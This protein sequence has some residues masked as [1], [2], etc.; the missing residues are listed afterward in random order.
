[1]VKLSTII[2]AHTLLMNGKQ[3]DFEAAAAQLGARKNDFADWTASVSAWASAFE[4]LT[5]AQ[6]KQAALL[7]LQQQLVSG[8]LP[9][10]PAFEIWNGRRFVPTDQFVKDPG[11]DLDVTIAMMQ[12]LPATPERGQWINALAELRAARQNRAAA[13]RA[14][15]DFRAGLA[16][17]VKLLRELVLQAFSREDV[18]RALVVSGAR[19]VLTPTAG[20]GQTPSK[21]NFASVDLGA[22][23][24]FPGFDTWTL[25]Y[26]GLNVYTVPV[27]RTIPPGELT[28]TTLDQLRQRVSL[29]IGTTLTAPTSPGRTLSAPFLGRYPLLAVGVRFGEYTRAVVGSVFYDANDP[30][31][32]SADKRLH[33][34]LFFGASLD[35][36]VI[37]I[38][39]NKL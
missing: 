13:E 37:D 14:P 3:G 7:L 39:T 1:L 2:Q 28:G 33:A 12:L 16:A 31:P 15:G 21:A 34:A 29:T 20:L 38:L 35:A 18:R 4:T 26:L 24:A 8:Q 23:V 10:P 5:A 19:S 27:D 6:D 9:K 36:D 22:A 17:Q 30:N 32:A 25:P 11:T